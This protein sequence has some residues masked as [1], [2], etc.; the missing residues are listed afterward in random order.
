LLGWGHDLLRD[1]P[2]T[3]ALG[4]AWIGVYAAMVWWQGSFHAGGADLLTGSIATST[5]HRFGDQTPA[6]IASGQLWRAL[7]STFVHYSL[8]HLG[9]NMI[10][11]VQFGR[12]VE[13]W[14]GSGPMLAIYAAIGF[15]GNALSG[16]VKIWS[17]APPLRPS[18][19]GSGV[20]V[21]LIA[22]I[23]LAGWRSRSRF[24]QYVQGQ[25]FLLLFL[26]GLMGV[27]YPRLDNTGHATGAVVGSLIGLAHPALVKAGRFFRR[28][29]GA[30]GLLA[31]L[32]CAY[33]QGE[34]VRAEAAA[35][36]RQAMAQRLAV[37]RL[38]L[39]QLLKV[40][41][42]ITRRGPRPPRTRVLIYGP[43]QPTDARLRADLRA[44]LKGLESLRFTPETDPVA[45]A[46]RRMR[47]LAL[48]ALTAAPTPNQYRTFL[49]DN[50]TVARR[51]DEELT[52]LLTPMVIEAAKRKAAQ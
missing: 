28:L 1:A 5:S 42:E 39:D 16:L 12:M 2:A 22:L 18:G 46:D 47:D 10:G 51:V 49:N 4:A 24:G 38:Q 21:G 26:T 36:T 3:A 30:A 23:A 50:T 7:T 25:M 31:M 9:L 29:A 27:L 37:A 33:A 34:S 41:R 11:L 40:Y 45:R 35:L 15:L 17:H 32:G 19:G 52:R 14:Y 48:R 20:V 6:A 13:E 44:L 8:I 43:P